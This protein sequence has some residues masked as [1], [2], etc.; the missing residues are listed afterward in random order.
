MVRGLRSRNYRLFFRG[1]SVSK[2]M[3]PFGSL[4]AGTLAQIVFPGRWWRA[5][6]CAR[7]FQK[8]RRAATRSRGAASRSDLSEHSDNCG[9]STALALRYT[10]TVL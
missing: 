7:Y 6:Q 8:R 9:L 5:E 3:A 10:V 4:L 1:Q 2:G